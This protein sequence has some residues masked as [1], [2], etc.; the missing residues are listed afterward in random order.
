M[1]TVGGLI[2]L[3][4]GAS[5]CT[6]SIPPPAAPTPTPV[7][8]VTAPGTAATPTITGTGSTEFAGL[9]PPTALAGYDNQQLSNAALIVSIGAG[10]GVPT[11]GQIIAVAVALQESSLR[12]LPIATDH[13]SLGLFQQRPSQG[14]GTPQQILD[15]T[16]ATNTFYD[17]LLAVPGW[18]HMTLTQAAQAVQR[19]AYPNAYAHWEPQATALVMLTTGV[20]GGCNG[21]DGASGAGLPLPAGFTLPPHTPEA[22]RV[23]ITWAL[24]QLGTPYS[25]GGDCTNPHASNPATECD[26]SSL[27]QQA[28]RAGG[29]TLPRTTGDQQHAGTPITT[30][31]DAHPGDLIFIPGSDGTMSNPGHVGLYLGDDLLVQAPHTGDVVKLTH[32]STWAHQIATIR[33]I[34]A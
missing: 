2:G 9:D 22:V 30:L 5:A 14:W 3:A 16:Y 24:Q 18:Q 17:H 10:R 20:T 4:G 11:Q 1:L 28:Y 27:V 12:N 32:A 6:P 26:C 23:A 21:G 34:A 13:D 31:T 15:P 19:S 25:Y 33:R 7:G 8:S 29:I